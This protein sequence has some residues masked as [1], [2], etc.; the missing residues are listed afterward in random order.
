MHNEIAIT[1]EKKKKYTHKVLDFGRVVTKYTIKKFPYMGVL[2]Y[3]IYRGS[4]T[5]QQIAMTPSI[6]EA[7]VFIT[8]EWE[9]KNI[10]AKDVRLG[11][12]YFFKGTTTMIFNQHPFIKEG[13][14][15]E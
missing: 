4:G 1:L 13:Y 3:C 5:G 14:T 10:R 15:I 11:S 7:I 2:H 6:S 12:C 9:Q 8:S